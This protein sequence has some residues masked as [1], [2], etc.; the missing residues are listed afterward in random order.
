M[1]NRLAIVLVSGAL[2][3]FA[4]GC[5]FAGSDATAP[6]PSAAEAGGADATGG[7]AAAGAETAGAKAF[8]TQTSGPTAGGGPTGGSE[9]SCCDWPNWRGPRHDGISRET[10]WNSDRWNFGVANS[11][12]AKPGDSNAGEGR[13][14]EESAGGLRVLWSQSV[15]VGFSSVSVAAG[16]CYTM[17]HEGELDF[18]WRLNAADG[19]VV[20]KHSYPCALVDNLHE[21]GPA[22][23]PTIDDGRV[24]TVSKE[25]HFLCLDVRDGS[26]L[27]TVEFQKQFDVKMPEWGFSCSPLI[28]DDL[29]IVDAGCLAAFDKKSGVLVWKTAD[30]RPG[31]GSA[32]PWTVDGQRLVTAL[33]NDA[34]LVARVADGSEVAQFPWQTDFATSACTPI[35]TGDLV[36]ISTGYNRGCALLKLAMGKL[37]PVYENKHMRN[38]M[39]SCVLRDGFLYGFDGNSHNR[40]TVNLVCMELAN[41]AVRWKKKGLGCGSLLL[42]GDRLLILGDEGELLTAPASPD[43]FEPLAKCRPLGGRCW[44]VPTLSHG[45]IYCRNAA[46]D[47]KCL[48]ARREEGR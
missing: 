8:A 16:S 41:G 23:T 4:F 37:E 10:D 46:G 42:A 36:F 12:G 18:V 14:G 15:G 3:N 13:S 11:G 39:N 35:A 44:T 25:G 30:Y 5:G 47:L 21:G 43:G 26:P 40:R 48:D 31:Y 17:G 9:P 29:V 22:A 33:N 24:Y 27:W 19:Q 38:H 32:T 1:M 7:S 6:A 20:W 2:L 45:R 34:L 28:V